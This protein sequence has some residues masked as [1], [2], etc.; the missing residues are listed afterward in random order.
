[1][2]S[3]GQILWNAI[4]VCE[5]S[6]TAWQMETPYEKRFGEPFKG[7]ILLLGALVEYL[8]SSPKDQMITHQFGKKVLPGIFLGYELI[9]SG[10]NLERR[11]D[12]EDLEMMDATQKR[13]GTLAPTLRT[14]ATGHG[15]RDLLDVL[16]TATGKVDCAGGDRC[17]C[18]HAWTPCIPDRPDECQTAEIVKVQR[19][20]AGP[21]AEWTSMLLGL[22]R[23]SRT[24]GW[25]VAAQSGMEPML[26]IAAL[27]RRPQRL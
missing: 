16:S 25:L 22:L 27:L 13:G 12:I 4:V 1:M 19:K 14:K 10:W 18:R 26:E 8:P 15:L 3:G 5:M 9:I 21:G 2:K 20:N 24:G 7:P 11:L 17:S 23:R 6:K